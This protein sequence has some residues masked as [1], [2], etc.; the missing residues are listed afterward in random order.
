MA[1]PIP[2]PNE[3]TPPIMAE[4]GFGY[5]LHPTQVVAA[6][7]I[8]FREN[9]T[10]TSSPPDEFDDLL[11]RLDAGI[12]HERVEWDLLLGRLSAAGS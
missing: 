12:A 6:E 10:P 9:R 4:P 11:G 3:A 5:V 8:A 7:T 2:H 1:D